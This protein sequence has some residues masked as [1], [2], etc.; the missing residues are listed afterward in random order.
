MI[1][2]EVGKGMMRL[3]HWYIVETV[4]FWLEGGG[5]R[6]IASNRVQMIE[7]HES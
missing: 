2:V 3:V 4:P 7:G 5:R 6:A 1:I